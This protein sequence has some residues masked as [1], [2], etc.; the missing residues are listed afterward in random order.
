MPP[1]P[2]RPTVAS[3]VVTDLRISVVDPANPRLI[4]SMAAL[5]PNGETLATRSRD[6]AINDLSGPVG[7]ALRVVVAAAIN[8]ADGA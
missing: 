6:F 4:A 1:I 7:D 3:R 5:D 8:W 2:Q